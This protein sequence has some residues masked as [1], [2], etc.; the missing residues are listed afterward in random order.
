MSPVTR[1]LAELKPTKEEEKNKVLIRFLVLFFF[2]TMLQEYR[3]AALTQNIISK[4]NER[5]Y[6]CRLIK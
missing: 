3:A 1:S 5:E 4:P 6:S 2:Y